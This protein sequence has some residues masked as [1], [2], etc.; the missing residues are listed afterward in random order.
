MATRSECVAALHRLVTALHA[1]DGQTRRERLPDRLLCCTIKDLD[2]T[3]VGELRD[4]AVLGRVRLGEPD[5]AQV[6]V[7]V[8]S[9]DL[10]ALES[11]ELGLGAALA[12][13]RIRIDA[14]VADWIRLRYALASARA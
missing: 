3:Y 6:R 12:Q 14:G 10:L 2:A 8:T 1:V 9:D 4:G 7:T 5:G 13:G 11:G